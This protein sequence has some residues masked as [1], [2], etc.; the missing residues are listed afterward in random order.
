MYL[1][2]MSIRLFG[3]ASIIGTVFFV[4]CVALIAREL[5]LDTRENNGEGDENRGGEGRKE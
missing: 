5:L 2:L 1:F 4:A 3:I